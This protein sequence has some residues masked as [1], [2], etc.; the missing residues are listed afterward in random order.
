[1]LE[2]EAIFKMERGKN[3]N[4]QRKWQ[5]NLISPIEVSSS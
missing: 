2:A 4:W 5:T 1:M 3:F